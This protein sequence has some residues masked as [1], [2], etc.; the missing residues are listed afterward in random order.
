MF[1]LGNGILDFVCWMLSA[2]VITSIYIYIS[3]YIYLYIYIYLA[4]FFLGGPLK[5]T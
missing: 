1:F 4:L 3:I 5:A 2:Y